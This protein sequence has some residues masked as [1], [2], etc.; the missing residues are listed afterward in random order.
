MVAAVPRLVDGSAGGSVPPGPGLVHPARSGSARTLGHL[1]GPRCS[2]SS[3]RTA[4]AL[5]PQ[6]SHRA[7]LS[8]PQPAQPEVMGPS[9]AARPAPARAC[10]AWEV[11]SAR[12]ISPDRTAKAQGCCHATEE[13]SAS[14]AEASFLGKGAGDSSS[15]KDCAAGLAVLSVTVTLCSRRPVNAVPH[16]ASSQG[17]AAAC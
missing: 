9:S 4:G 2:R 6:K 17:G 12:L 14:R 1:D 5:G 10:P 8:G 3:P 7:G 13:A 11:P 16:R 15:P